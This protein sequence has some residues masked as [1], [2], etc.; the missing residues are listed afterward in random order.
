[1]AIANSFD[2][3][4]EINGRTADYDDAGGE[5]DPNSGGNCS[6]RLERNIMIH[7]LC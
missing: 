1:M 3:I 2:L 7:R 4:A 5:T 6:K